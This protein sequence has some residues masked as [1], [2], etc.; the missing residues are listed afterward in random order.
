MTKK[1]KKKTKKKIK[2]SKKKIRK[3]KRRKKKGKSKK[4]GKR[5]ISKSDELICEVKNPK[6]WFLVVSRSHWYDKAKG[7]V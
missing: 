2:K 3:L 6:A 7:F 4:I 1:K 5:K